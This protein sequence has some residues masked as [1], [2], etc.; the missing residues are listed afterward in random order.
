MLPTEKLLHAIGSRLPEDLALLETRDVHTLF[1][2]RRSALC[3]MYRY[4]VWNARTRPVQRLAQRYTYHCWHAL[5]VEKM[6]TA[7]RQFLGEK[8]FASMAA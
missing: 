5:D 1:N 6:Q 4:R 2:A 3:K 7:A 8:D